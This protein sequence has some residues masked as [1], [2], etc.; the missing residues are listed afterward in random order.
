[1]KLIRL[2]WSDSHKV[3]HLLDWFGVSPCREPFLGNQKAVSVMTQT[4]ESQ[5]PG[6]GPE[7]RSRQQYSPCTSIRTTLWGG[8]DLLSDF[9]KWPPAIVSPHKKELR[10]RERQSREER[11]AEKALM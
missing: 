4:P 2:R 8:T 7:G 5:N 10:V 1:M 9:L 6:T 3:C 11:T